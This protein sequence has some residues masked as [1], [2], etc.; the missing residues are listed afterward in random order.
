MTTESVPVAAPAAGAAISAEGRVRRF[1]RTERAT[2]WMQASAFLLLLISGFILQLPVLEST[3]G[4]RELV[5]E[6]HL[7]AAFFFF[8]GPAIIAL[9]GDRRSV[10]RDV[11]AVDRW[12]ADDIQWLTP[13]HL[14]GAPVPQGRFNAGQKL[15]AIFVVWSTLTFTITGLIIWQNRR[16]STDLVS[17][18]NA[19]HTTLAYLALVA[20][21]GHLYLATAYPK[22]RH[23]LRAITQG[24]VNADWARDHHPKWL[25]QLSAPPRPPAH[26]GLRTAAQ[27]GLGAFACLFFARVLFFQLGANVTDRV[28]GRLYALTAWPGA[29]SIHPQTGVHVADWIG[30]GY[31]LLCVLAW[32]AVDQLRR[33]PARG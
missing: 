17:H 2:H 11:E 21:L 13:S 3:I 23:A 32:I 27:L 1:T 24:W 29:A 14:A 33:L 8:F 28:T 31:F 20:F 12:D 25:Q 22:T 18:A 15:N 30:I 26:D 5:R 4:N 10:A 6:I 16:F 19:I 7:S 9:S